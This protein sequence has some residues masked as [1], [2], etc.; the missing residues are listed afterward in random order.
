MELIRNTFVPTLLDQIFQNLSK[1]HLNIL[2]LLG[3]V[4]LVS[5]VCL[6]LYY[7]YF[8]LIYW[9]IKKTIRL[10]KKFF[11]LIVMCGVCYMAYI[12]YLPYLQNIFMV[13]FFV[14]RIIGDGSI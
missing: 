4:G 9:P 13:S 3:Y 6:F 5:E 14:F 12:K 8:W 2:L 11:Y 1:E 7:A 10:L